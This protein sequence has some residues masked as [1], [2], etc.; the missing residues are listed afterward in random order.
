MPFKMP[1]VWRE[2]ATTHSDKA[3]SRSVDEWEEPKAS[4]LCTSYWIQLVKIM[5]K[6]TLEAAPSVIKMH[7]AAIIKNNPKGCIVS[8]ASSL[9][10]CWGPSLPYQLWR[11]RTCGS[12]EVV[13]CAG[14]RG[15][16]GV[17][18][19]DCDLFI[20]NVRNL[21]RPCNLRC[22]SCRA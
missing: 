7:H 12:V 13:N 5:F 8:C 2:K 21:N 18:L 6:V 17:Y 22:T 20:K 19:L 9:C 15:E 4:P 1:I 3:R 10:K 14:Q 16:L 11:T